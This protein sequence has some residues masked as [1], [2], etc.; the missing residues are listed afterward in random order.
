LLEKPGGKRLVGILRH[1]WED[2]F[3]VALKWTGIAWVGFI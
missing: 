1:R 2:N 3:K